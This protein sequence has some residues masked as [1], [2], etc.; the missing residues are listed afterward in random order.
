MRKNTTTE[1]TPD[2]RQ[3]AR[4]NFKNLLQENSDNVLDLEGISCQYLEIN[5]FK[6]KIA[7]V[8]DSFSCLSLNIRSL[9]KKINELRD[10]IADISTD[11]FN[12]SVISLQEVWNVPTNI[13]TEITGYHPF[14]Y[15][16]RNTNRGG[17]VGCWIKNHLNYEVIE[18]LSVF[19][20]NI[21]ESI[22][23]KINISKSKFKI[24]GNIYKPPSCNIQMFND[25]LDIL[26]KISN[27]KV[28]KK[29]DEITLMGDIN[30]DLLKFENHKATN[31]YLN[32]LLS[33]SFLPV[34]T[35]P[36]RVTQNTASLIDHIFTNSKRNRLEGGILYS[37]ISDHM[38][39]FSLNVAPKNGDIRN[40]IILTRNMSKKNKDAF[41]KKIEDSNIHSVVNDYNPITAFE[42]FSNILNSNFEESFPLIESKPNKNNTPINPWM[43]PGL[44]ISKKE[45]DKLASKKLKNPTDQ[46]IS[47]YKTFY[48]RYRSLIR[49]SKRNYYASKFAEY[50]RDIKNTWKVI[51]SLISNKKKQNDLP[52]TFYN[53]ELSFEGAKN[54]AN[55]FN[56][57]FV[58][59]GPNLAE[60]ISNPDV[61]FEDF[62]PNPTRE[63]FVFANVTPEIII[64][65]LSR[66]KSKSSS[67]EDNISTK[68]M[69]EIIHIIVQ[70][71]THLFNLSFKTGYIPDNYKC[72]KIIP[73]YKSD[74]KD[75]F[76]NYRPI[77]ILSAFSKL[78]EKIAAIQM[79]KYI[80]KFKFFYEH[81]YGFR[82]QHDTNHPLLHFL[83]KIYNGL[84]KPNSEYTLSIFL[85]LKK[86]FDTCQHSILIKKM[87]YYGF[88]G[89]ASTWFHNYL[90]NRTQYVNINNTKSSKMTITCGVPQGSVLGPILFLLYIND[91]PNATNF[92]TSLFADDTGFLMSSPDLK[93]LFEDSNR[94]LE[95]ASIWFKANKL[96][97]NISKTKYIIFRNHKMP[98]DESLCKLFI[99]NVEL[100]RI[101]NNCTDKYF[102]F[103]GV[104]LDEH[105][106]WS[107]HTSY[108]SNKISSA[109]FA[110]NQ[111][112]NIFPLQI[113]KSIYNT[114]I[115]S[116]IEYGLL[117]WG[118][119]NYKSL[120]NIKKLQKKA[121][122]IISNKGFKNH[123]DPLFCTL[124]LLKF[125]DLVKLKIC[126]FMYKFFYSKLPESFNNM[127]EPLSGENR[128]K[129]LKLQTAKN[130][131]LESFPAV[132]FPK[133]W[134]LLP[135][136]LKNAST[137]KSLKKSMKAD[138]IMDYNSFRCT[139]RNCFSCRN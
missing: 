36:T 61:N 72:A 80:N 44:L 68:L 134:N 119:G 34:I 69:K 135:I 77:S 55:G 91:L 95:K 84:N 85:D 35:L 130:K 94:E 123:T 50:S 11:T 3:G 56:D 29:A 76:N 37:C 70:P 96:S 74:K 53:G 48:S 32:S 14:I 93:K 4:E 113:R 57:F 139:T 127:F 10:L 67:G 87:S 73:I 118:L 99:E 30:I 39:I 40:E 25:T 19:N 124:G 131:C 132:I 101:G 7:N 108:V 86:A 102:K 114:L 47:S 126:E 33:N 105:L 9:P 15:K 120:A 26:G 13:N 43:T 81:Q 137:S 75:Q 54:I 16:L 117:S 31:D 41:C 18:E 2:N 98:I 103:V 89:V 49:E 5:Q 107:Y 59:I 22:F 88:R 64:N 52:S 21:F 66:L 62:M 112:K 79:F 138:F 121:I 20:E 23:I 116:H 71:L 122:R 28:L 42:T 38:P 110:L 63:N 45:K 104:R 83:D 65:T 1:D 6:D 133:T 27:D 136:H 129:C 17:G 100:E 97:L 82:P 24:I 8:K 46:N 58:N 115:K 111:L 128:T 92:F 106:T 109:I 78:L 12:F 60:K 90:H 51:N 125:D